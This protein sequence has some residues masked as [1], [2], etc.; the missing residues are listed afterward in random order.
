MTKLTMGTKM[1]AAL[2]LLA[3]KD[4]AKGGA[5]ITAIAERLGISNAAASS[6]VGDL[7]RKGIDVAKRRE[8]AGWVLYTLNAVELVDP[9]PAKA[10]AEAVKAV[11]A[12]AKAGK[13]PAR[14]RKAPAK[15]ARKAPAKT[16]TAK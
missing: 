10:R 15:T 3:T 1:A 13:A 9:A 5:S 7:R 12:V 4:A 6:L 11:K 14:K 8:G 2:N 16:P